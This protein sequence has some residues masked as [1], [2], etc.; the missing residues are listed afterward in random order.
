MIP[1]RTSAERLVVVALAGALVAYAAL[2][3]ASHRWIPALV[4]PLVAVLL[5]LRH[6]RAR[7]SA[8]V[9]FSAVVVR[10]LVAGAWPLALFGGAALAVMQHPA[11]VRAW[12][13]VRVDRGTRLL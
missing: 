3:V 1:T 9:F 6:R 10:G 13:R 4:A 7:F 11:A 12:P 5:A 8:Y 2:A